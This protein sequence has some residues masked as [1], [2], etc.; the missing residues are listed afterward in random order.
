MGFALLSASL[1]TS[2]VVIEETGYILWGD[3]SD[4]EWQG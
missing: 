3:V 1:H 2:W 4:S